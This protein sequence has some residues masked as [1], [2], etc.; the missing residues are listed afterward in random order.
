M[1]SGY[2]RDW[3]GEELTTIRRAM[4]DRLW[5]ALFAGLAAFAASAIFGKLPGVFYAYLLFDLGFSMFFVPSLIFGRQVEQVAFFAF[6]AVWLAVGW[7]L[8][9]LL[10]RLMFS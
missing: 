9:G 4:K 6:T 1:K 2:G 7:L 10:T 3:R 8:A 5:T